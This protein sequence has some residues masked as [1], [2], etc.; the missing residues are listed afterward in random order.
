MNLNSNALKN[1]FLFC[2]LS[3][4]SGDLMAQHMFKEKFE[5]CK[6][7]RF[8]TEKDSISVQENEKDIIYILANNFTEENVKK[9]KGL[10]SLQ[11]IVDTNGNSCLLSITNDTNLKT[12]KLNIKQIID[13]K[14]TWRKPDEKTS[15]LLGIKFYGSEVEKKRIGMSKEKGFHAIR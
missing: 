4:F 5:D 9:I 2:L 10:L 6:T 14:L 15:V 7:K 12:K 13:K 8:T 3:I 1:L 11:I